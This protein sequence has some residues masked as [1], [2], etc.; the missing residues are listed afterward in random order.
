MNTGIGDA[1]NLAWKLAAVLQGRAAEAI[2]DT[3]STERTAFAQ[4]L[5]NVTDRIFDAV[6]GRGPGP[7][8]VRSLFIPFIAPVLLRMRRIRRS[9]FRLVS[10]VRIRYPHSVSTLSRGHA[11]AIHGGDRLPWLAESDNFA[12]LSSLDWQLHV[13]GEPS[14]ELRRLA[15]A[16]GIALHSFPFDAG[17]SRAG[18]ERD[19][20]YLIRPDG[21]VAVAASGADSSQIADFLEDWKIV[22]VDPAR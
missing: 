18:F 13:A 7:H 10:Q 2:L 16:R 19:A 17:A 3:Y 14:I 20:A 4:V 5:V 21:H 1:V 8:L 12:A 22:P 9:Q 15:K 11:G 6:V